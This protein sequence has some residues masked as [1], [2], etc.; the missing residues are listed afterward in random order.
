MKMQLEQ[1][2]PL[3]LEDWQCVVRLDWAYSIRWTAPQIG[4]EIKDLVILYMPKI[5]KSL[6]TLTYNM[7]KRR[8][9]S[10][11]LLVYACWFNFLLLRC[12]L[13]IEYIDLV[14]VRRSRLTCWQKA[15]EQVD[16]RQYY[17]FYTMYFSG[18]DKRLITCVKL[19]S[20][21]CVN[22]Q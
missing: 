15:R 16:G 19:D 4:S 13:K 11:C 21:C 2:R 3:V 10:F 9:K 7:M 17:A 12:K 5:S 6:A 8:G 18:F 20:T 14:I 1:R 22:S